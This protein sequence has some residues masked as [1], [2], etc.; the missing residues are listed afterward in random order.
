M[1]PDCRSPRIRFRTDFS[2]QEDGNIKM[3][4]QV[5]PDGRYW[6]DDD[7]YGETN[8]E[9]V[10]L[11]TFIDENSCFTG[12]FRLNKTGVVYHNE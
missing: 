11:C 9:E 12:P 8:D 1:E 3:I 10:C 4:W 5:Q 6:E 7:G 2:Q